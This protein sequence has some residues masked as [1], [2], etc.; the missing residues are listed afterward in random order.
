MTE[1]AT[2]PRGLRARDAAKYVGVS[3][4]LL[5]REAR[6]GRAPAS[7]TLTPGRVVW[8]R[9]DLDLYLDQRKRGLSWTPG[10]KISGGS[11]F[12]WR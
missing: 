4:S 12:D 2:A 8:D 9:A 5:H 3:V 7:F 10:A 11:G 6:A 1:P